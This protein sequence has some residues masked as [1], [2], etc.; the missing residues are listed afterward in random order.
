MGKE[1][2]S[3]VTVLGSLPIAGQII[4]F[5]NFEDLL[6]LTVTANAG[7]FIGEIDPTL[8]FMGN[9][10]LYI[11][12]RTTAAAEDDY[13][14][15]LINC[16]LQPSKKISIS[17]RFN[18]PS[19]VKIKYLQLIA[20]LYDGANIHTARIQLDSTN[21]IWQ[22]NTDADADTNITGSDIALFIGGWHHLSMIVDFNNDTFQHFVCDYLSLNLAN[23]SFYSTANAGPARL[24]IATKLV[25]AGASPAIA[26]LDQFIILE[27]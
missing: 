18:V 21:N 9:Q 4:F 25:T 7:N 5:D 6:H 3:P 10:S 16:H 13:V 11:S 26:N 15:A 19:L 23:V 14:Q 20:N 27:E 24:A 22:R 1:Y 2:I 12:S 8:A 17:T